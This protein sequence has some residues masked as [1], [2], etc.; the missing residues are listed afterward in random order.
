[1]G[2][3][4]V[5][6]ANVLPLENDLYLAVS[7]TQLQQQRYQSFSSH[8]KKAWDEYSGSGGGPLK[9]PQR[10]RTPM[11]PVCAAPDFH[12]Q[13]HAGSR[14]PLGHQ[15]LTTALR[16]RRGA[17]EHRVHALCLLSKFTYFYLKNKVKVKEER[18]VSVSGILCPFGGFSNLDFKHFHA[19]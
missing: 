9:S 5:R 1:M 12:L 19:R 11:S 13:C 10:S 15:P 16:K 2:D 3:G 8:L 4:D 18:Q 6:I 7:K 14:W 17:E